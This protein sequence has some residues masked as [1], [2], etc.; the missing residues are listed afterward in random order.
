MSSTPAFRSSMIT[1][2]SRDVS[3]LIIMKSNLSDI[4]LA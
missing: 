1:N 4:Q 3:L 2:R